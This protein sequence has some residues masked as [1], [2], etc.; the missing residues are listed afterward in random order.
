MKSFRTT[1]SWSLLT[2][3][4]PHKPTGQLIHLT[5]ISNGLQQ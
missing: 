2:T 3:R 5:P 1:V 4:K